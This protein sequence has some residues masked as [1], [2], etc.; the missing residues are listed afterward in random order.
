ML[1]DQPVHQAVQFRPAAGT[2]HSGEDGNPDRDRRES[3]DFLGQ[4]ASP[5]VGREGYRIDGHHH[6]RSP[7]GAEDEQHHDRPE[8]LFLVEV[9]ESDKNEINDRY[10][11]RQHEGCAVPGIK[12]GCAPS[13]DANNRN[14]R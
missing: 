6:H 11:D 10:H 13:Q 2:A 9:Q 4:G 14:D 5:Q 8:G 3:G 1:E 7:D 12:H